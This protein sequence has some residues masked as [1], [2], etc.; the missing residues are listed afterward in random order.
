MRLPRKEHLG[1]IVF[2]EITLIIFNAFPPVRKIFL[3]NEIVHH[4]FRYMVSGMAF[5]WH[6]TQWYFS[7]CSNQKKFPPGE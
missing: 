2:G 3:A 1:L 4:L 6:Y 7:H 5:V